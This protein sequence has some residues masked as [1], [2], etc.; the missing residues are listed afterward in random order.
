MKGLS[1]MRILSIYTERNRDA[2]SRFFPVDGVQVLGCGSDKGIQCI[3][4][5]NCRS[6]RIR[7]QNLLEYIILSNNP[8]IS[9][10]EKALRSVS[11]LAFSPTRGLMQTRLDEFLTENGTIN[12]EG[13]IH[14]RLGE[15]AE[16]INAI[17]YSIVKKNLYKT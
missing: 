16:R 4:V 6:A 17:L 8:A 9:D 1:D 11:E 15:Y 2:L 13:Y 10:G 14:F 5:S 7:L 12:I 3:Y